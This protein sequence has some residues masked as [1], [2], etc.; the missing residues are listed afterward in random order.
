MAWDEVE[1]KLYSGENDGE[2]CIWSL[3]E[4][5]PIGVLGYEGNPRQ[6]RDDTD[7]P[8]YNP[9]QMTLA[10]MKKIKKKLAFDEE[11]GKGHFDLV[12]DMVVI[13]KLQYLASC[14]LD[15]KVILWDTI[16]KQAKRIYSEHRLGVLSLAYNEE[17][18]LL[19]SAGF[20][21]DIFVWNPYID[22]PI[23]KMTSHNAA[24]LMLQLIEHSNQMVSVDLLSI[25]KI[26]DIRNFS[27]TQTIPIN[28][29][30]ELHSGVKFDCISVIPA[31]KHSRLIFA[32]N[33][34]I[35][36]DYD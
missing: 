30:I 10:K 3:H 23:N 7:I 31:W 2:I 14:S 36:Y 6:P 27:C 15:M 26:W 20:D 9:E 19:F 16:T 25:V 12:T 18:I 29:Q 21:H 22:Q 5:H 33:M 13:Q 28:E 35:A 8:A 32:G 1:A 34:M 11:R 24:V 4:T 17:K